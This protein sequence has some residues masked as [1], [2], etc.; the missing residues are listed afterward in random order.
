MGRGGRPAG[1]RLKS[2][3][4]GNYNRLVK[5]NFHVSSSCSVSNP[6]RAF[7]LYIKSILTMVFYNP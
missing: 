2:V 6:N 3:V 7:K 4:A 5:F 1:S